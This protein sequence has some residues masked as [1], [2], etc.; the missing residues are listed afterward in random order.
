MQLG[1]EMMSEMEAKGWVRSLD[2]MHS[3]SLIK[4]WWSPLDRNL[5]HRRRHS[6][7]WHYWQFL[8]ISSHTLSS[9]PS[10]TWD[11]SHTSWAPPSSKDGLLNSLFRR[12]PQDI[13][14]GESVMVSMGCKLG[15]SKAQ[16]SSFHER[17]DEH[18]W[19]CPRAA[20]C[21][22]DMSQTTPAGPRRHSLE[23]RN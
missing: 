12:S 22:A 16:F 23:D 8:P 2:S 1:H 15:F 13:A 7:N 18:L 14:P 17:T 4:W 10:T 6:I 11:S 9:W 19:D 5:H 20:G 21:T 3:Q